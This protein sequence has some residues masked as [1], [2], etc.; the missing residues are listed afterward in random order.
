MLARLGGRRPRRP[1]GLDRCLPSLNLLLVR[2]GQWPLAVALPDHTILA[3]AATGRIP[4]GLHRAND[5]QCAT[6]A[7]LPA[8]TRDDQVSVDEAQRTS[9]PR[10]SSIRATLNPT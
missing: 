8:V 3:P 4:G 7:R 5:L 2:L 9:R 6:V 1:V 10:V